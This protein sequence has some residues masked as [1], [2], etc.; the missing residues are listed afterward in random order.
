MRSL[1]GWGVLG[2]LVL[3]LGPGTLA[4]S[5]QE[6]KKSSPK[7][8]APKKEAPKEEAA[9][10]MEV[11]RQQARALLPLTK[12]ALGR[13]MLAA[14]PELPS[15]EAPRVV[16]Y[17]KK[18][19]QALSSVQAKGRS[20][21]ELAGFERHELDEQFFYFTRYGTPLASVR[22]F[23]LAGQAGLE[24][25]PGVRILDFGFGSIGQLRLLASVGAHVFGVE[26]DPLLQ[27]LYG[28]PSDT[29]AIPRASSA[30]PGADGELRLE[31]GQF[32][33]DAGL[34]E[35]VGEG[36]DLFVSKNTL[37]RGYI[38]PEKEV[39]P[40]YLVQLGVDDA[41]FVSEMHRVLKPGGLALVYNLH[42]APS[43]EGEPYKHW[44]DGRFPFAR[45]HCEQAGFEVLAFDVD[46]TEFA[47][48][49]GAALGWK[50]QMDLSTDLF[51]T[52]T[53][54]RKPRK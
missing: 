32:P 44:A 8:E 38:H 1:L 6:A 3:G 14:V 26:V 47:R 11:L 41:T 30:G 34:V 29:G 15:L 43:S 36:F 37:K 13:Q 33:A 49:M 35:R 45:E 5:E 27:I 21:E 10:T 54:L 46:D 40:R 25:S 19:R 51:A 16:F 7:K 12:S 20:E 48:T 50:E 23:D 2:L 28:H 22:A 42:P 31:F 18:D 39:D 24:P 53:L 9:N 52:Y 4:A 17:N